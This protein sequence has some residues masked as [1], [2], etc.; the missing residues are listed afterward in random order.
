MQT[1]SG[2]WYILHK[3]DHSYNKSAFREAEKRGGNMNALKLE[4][5][6]VDYLNEYCYKTWS[7]K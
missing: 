6:I 1:R 2:Y 4:R 7:K 3:Q 5:M